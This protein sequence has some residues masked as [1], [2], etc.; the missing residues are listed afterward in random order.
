MPA[1]SPSAAASGSSAQASPVEQ[2][3]V[4]DE[5]SSLATGLRDVFEETLQVALGHSATKGACLYSCLL[6]R[7]AIKQSTGMRAVVRGGGGEHDGYRDSRGRLHGHS[8]VEATSRET[9]RW[10]VDITA[11]QFG[12]PKTLVL[13]VAQA[14]KHYV[15]GDQAVIDEHLA[16]F[17][18]EE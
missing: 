1:P 11:D 8:W 2:S 7:A 4:R 5:L 14:R 16:D 9:G 13:P 18:K 15:P 12:G 10:V 17:S 3:S 6:V